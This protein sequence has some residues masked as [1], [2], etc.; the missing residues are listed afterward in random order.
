ML[1]SDLLEVM[2]AV[3]DQ[4]LGEIEVKFSADSAC[5]LVMASGGYPASYEKGHEI[6]VGQLDENVEVFVAELQQKLRH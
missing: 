2:E 4:R 3:T 5:C 6:T 1:E